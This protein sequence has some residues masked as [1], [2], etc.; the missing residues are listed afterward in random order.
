MGKIGAKFSHLL[1]VRAGCKKTVFLTTSLIEGKTNFLK[2]MVEKEI[3][4]FVKEF[5]KLLR[6]YVYV[7]VY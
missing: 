3:D 7:R 4:E 1:T 5:Y 2:K 6:T